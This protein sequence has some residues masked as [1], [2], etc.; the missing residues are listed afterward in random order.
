MAWQGRPSS[1]LPHVY[2]QLTNLADPNGA[3]AAREELYNWFVT[4]D[5]AEQKQ[6]IVYNLIE[7]YAR[8]A[9]SEHQ[10]AVAEAVRH[11]SS[12]CAGSDYRARLL[13]GAFLA[14]FSPQTVADQTTRGAALMCASIFLSAQPRQR[15]VA[16]G[17]ELAGAA[18]RGFVHCC[19]QSAANIS[20]A[21]EGY[22]HVIKGF[23][24]M[25]S[26]AQP[27]ALDGAKAVMAVLESGALAPAAQLSCFAAVREL[28]QCLAP[29]ELYEEHIGDLC[30]ALAAPV[31]P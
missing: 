17:D 1:R 13:Q 29:G 28:G 9:S 5:A 2:N 7:L 31:E 10:Q 6:T 21:L 12:S 20:V 25:R 30:S 4:C 23:K 26:F 3:H 16:F 18:V 24:D 15:R 14:A 19:S 8:S 22:V 11:L 27:T